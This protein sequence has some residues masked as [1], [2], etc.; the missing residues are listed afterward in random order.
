MNLV[1]K[2]NDVGQNGSSSLITTGCLKG[3]HFRFHERPEPLKPGEVYEFRI[4]LWATSYLVPKGHRLR[5]SVSCSDFPRIWPTP[6]NPKIRVFF[7]GKHASSIRFPVV[8]PLATP[9][10]S[11]EIKRPDPTVN[12][13]PCIIDAAPLWK[14]EQDLATG[15]LAVITGTMEQIRIPTGGKLHQNHIVK[16]SVTASQPDGAKVEGETTFRL[17]LPVAG[18]VQIEAKTLI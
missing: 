7:G 16:A 5:L 1:A 17:E 6:S 12:R 2:L 15:S 3:S 13:F 14:I 9:V 11:P 4:P 18:L 10:D 8:R